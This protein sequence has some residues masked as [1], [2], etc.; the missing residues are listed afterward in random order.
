MHRIL[1]VVLV[2]F[3]VAGLAQTVSVMDAEGQ[4]VQIKDASRVLTLGGPVTEIVYALEQGSRV[5]ATDTSSYY[6]VMA[7]QLPKVGYQRNLSAEGIIAQKPTLVIGTTEAGPPAAIK[8]LRDSGITTLILSSEPNVEGAK[9]KIRKIGQVFAAKA[10]AEALIRA[11]DSELNRAKTLFSS[12]KARPKVV[13][14]YAR[15]A[16]ALSVSGRGSSADSMIALAG[17]LNAVQAYEG[18]KPLTSEALIAA[19]PDVILMLENGLESIGG[20]DGA[21]KLPGVA[22]TNA[23]KN[24][25]IV[26]MDDLYLLSFGPRLGRAVLDLTYLLHPELKRPGGN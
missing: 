15:G 5:V 6:P 20:V 8:Q 3:G 9:D 16:G 25:R 2:I 22:L 4:T 26:A 7:A 24:R 23:G 19:N 14:V 12:V 11:M 10:R 21:L 17:G 18:Y 1:I 13:F